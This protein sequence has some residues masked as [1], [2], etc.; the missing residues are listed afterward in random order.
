M[1]KKDRKEQ[2]DK[3]K[4]KLEALNQKHEEETNKLLHN[5]EQEKVCALCIYYSPLHSSPALKR[6]E[7]NSWH[8]KL[9]QLV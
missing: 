4:A 8:G 3:F 2:E 6:L 5:F 1:V 7:K 9:C